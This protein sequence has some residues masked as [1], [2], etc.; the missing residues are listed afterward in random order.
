MKSF[1]VLIFTPII[2]FSQWKDF[3]VNSK[4]KLL[5]NK[6]FLITIDDSRTS[7]NYK[8]LIFSGL[9]D[10]LDGFVPI[11]KD[12]DILKIGFS[13][14]LWSNNTTF[15]FEPGNFGSVYPF[16]FHV[17]DNIKKVLIPSFSNDMLDVSQ[18]YCALD[19]GDGTIGQTLIPVML[20]TDKQIDNFVEL[21]KM[22]GG[23]D[24]SNNLS[25]KNLKRTHDFLMNLVTIYD[26]NSNF[27]KN[28]RYRKK[29]K[30]FERNYNRLT[31]GD[32]W[33]T[34][35][36]YQ[37]NNK[38]IN[39]LKIKDINSGKRKNKLKKLE[40]LTPLFKDSKLFINSYNKVKVKISSFDSFYELDFDNYFFIPINDLPISPNFN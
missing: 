14:R 11:Y 29:S 35:F 6:I 1:F 4:K 2:I 26:Q 33:N 3:D 12:L 16:L 15:F 9:P 8:D 22:L 38:K 34:C 25:L 19:Y 28:N 10:S 17:D 32:V 27:N 37:M 30:Q 36:G 40:V 24:S 7:Y 21:L 23:L 13:H 39:K 20:F 18:G 31:V 5:E